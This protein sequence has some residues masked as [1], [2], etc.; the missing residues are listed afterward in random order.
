MARSLVLFFESLYEPIFDEKLC[1]GYK[2]GS[3]LTE[4]CHQVLTLLPPVHHTIFTAICRFLQLILKKSRKKIVTEFVL[5]FV[6]CLMHASPPTVW[7]EKLPQKYAQGM[8]YTTLGKPSNAVC[9][10]VDAMHKGLV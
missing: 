2:V 5:I 10:S 6:N 8:I 4:F 9:R 3:N 7:I 1:N